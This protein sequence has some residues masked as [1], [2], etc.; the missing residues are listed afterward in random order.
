MKRRL[1][2]AVDRS[3]A[4]WTY[5]IGYRRRMEKKPNNEELQHLHS[6]LDIIRT[7]N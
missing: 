1:L 2:I 5:F 7:E 6:S 4:A 3:Q